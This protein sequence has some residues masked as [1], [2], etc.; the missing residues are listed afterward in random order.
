MQEEKT[1][2][3]DLAEN[4]VEIGETYYKLAQVNIVEK[5]TVVGSISIVIVCYLFLFLMIIF[6]GGIGLAAYL[7]TLFNS[8]YTGYFIV[9]GLFILLAAI[10]F[11][12]RKKTIIPLLKNA[13][14][15]QVYE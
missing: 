6:F 15:K 4:I 14:V 7:N 9:C 11:L 1:I 3:E 8:N 12:L 5:A 2:I 13:I 10:L